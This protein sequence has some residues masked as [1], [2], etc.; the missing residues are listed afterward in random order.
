MLILGDFIIQDIV[1]C[2]QWLSVWHMPYAIYRVSIHCILTGYFPF[3]LLFL[4]SNIVLWILYLYPSL[5]STYQITLYI[6][7]DQSNCL[8]DIM[9]DTISAISFLMI[10]SIRRVVTFNKPIRTIFPSCLLKDRLQ[11]D[12]AKK[13]MGKKKVDH[14]GSRILNLENKVT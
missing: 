10:R 12:D 4:N 11:N 1:L 8:F 9:W 13:F 5:N 2:F 3:V 6:R 14:F 7:V